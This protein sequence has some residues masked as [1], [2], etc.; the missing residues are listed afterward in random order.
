MADT[1]DTQAIDGARLHHAVI[2]ASGWEG[3]A[4]TTVDGRTATLAVVDETGRVIESG[5]ELVSEIWTVAVMAYRSLLADEHT[6]T[7]WSS[8]SG[9]FQGKDRV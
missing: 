4:V 6:L 9:L 2:S 8:P 7:V 1:S 5:P 3:L